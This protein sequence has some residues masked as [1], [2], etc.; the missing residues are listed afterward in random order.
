MAEH[1]V[2][3]LQRRWFG[4]ELQEKLAEYDHAPSS[5]ELLELIH[6]RQL[7]GGATLYVRAQGGKGPATV[8]RA[9]ELA[10]LHG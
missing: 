5:A 9:R 3:F 2:V 4:E 7:G 10:D 8:V 1:Y 6:R